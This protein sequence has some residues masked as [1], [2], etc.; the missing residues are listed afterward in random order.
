MI[1]V[2]G[3][4]MGIDMKGYAGS[5]DL[6]P[7]LSEQNLDTPTSPKPPTHKSTPAPQTEDVEMAA[8][9]DEE[10]KAKEAAEAAKKAGNEAYKKR[11]FE[12]AAKSFEKAWD[13]WPKD[14]TYLTNLGG[15]KPYISP[16][17]SPPDRKTWPQLCTLSKVTTTR[18]S[19]HARKLLRRAARYALSRLGL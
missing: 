10:S 18:P 2:L 12:D 16:I 1:D 7:G 9:D 14:I 5:D 4:L 6:P 11:D 15:K 19:R 17:S 8:E 3:V 13:L